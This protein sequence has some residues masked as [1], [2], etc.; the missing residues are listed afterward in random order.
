MKAMFPE[1][2]VEALEKIILANL[3]LCPAIER[4]GLIGS[5][6]RGQQE[7]GSDVDLLIKAEDTEYSEMLSNFGLH[8][9]DIL[10]YRYNKR[11]EIVRYSLALKR[12][13]NEP[14]AGKDWYFQEGYQQMLKEVVWLY[15]R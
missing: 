5:Y 8:I 10:D 7:K 11:L 3:S 12:A 14:Q 9:S 6:A 13:E 15:E 1:L 4:V 2:S